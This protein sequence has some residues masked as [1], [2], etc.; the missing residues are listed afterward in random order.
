MAEMAGFDG[1]TVMAASHVPF[2]SVAVNDCLTV[3]SVYAARRRAQIAASCDCAHDV[4]TRMRPLKDRAGNF[5]TTLH[6][7]RGS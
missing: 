3:A 5:A 2:Y 1:E 6:F 7:S 4:N